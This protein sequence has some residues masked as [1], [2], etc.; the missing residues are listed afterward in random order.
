MATNVHLHAQHL[1]NWAWECGSLALALGNRSGGPCTRE[2]ETR[3]SE[4]EGYPLLHSEFKASLSYMR[5]SIKKTGMDE[6]KEEREMEK[7][8][9][10]SKKEG[11][12]ERE[13]R[14]EEGKQVSLSMGGGRGR[15]AEL[16]HSL[17][18]VDFSVH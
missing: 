13:G 10:E 15:L 9:E 17:L 18:A 12:M 5:L 6:R 16:P 4:V 7:E 14:K 8:R 11:G 2:V 3:G 1:R